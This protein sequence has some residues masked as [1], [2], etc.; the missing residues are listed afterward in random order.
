MTYERVDGVNDAGEQEVRWVDPTRPVG[1][2]VRAV[3]ARG[4]GE[5]DADFEARVVETYTI[6]MMMEQKP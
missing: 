5:S 2:Q 1:R 4:D 3:I 6:L